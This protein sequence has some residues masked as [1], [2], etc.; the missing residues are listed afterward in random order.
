VA[1]FQRS[2]NA[3]QGTTF[4]MQTTTN[5]PRF[6]HQKAPQKAKTPSKNEVLPR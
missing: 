6:H 4:T 1:Y 5:S 2:K 3:L